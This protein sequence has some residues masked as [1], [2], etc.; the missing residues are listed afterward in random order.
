MIAPIRSTD[1]WTDTFTPLICI[2]SIS[3]FSFG[4]RIISNF[5][6][7]LKDDS[8]TRLRFNVWKHGTGVVI[9]LRRFSQSQAKWEWY[10][11]SYGAAVL[12]PYKELA[13]ECWA[14]DGGYEE[15]VGQYWPSG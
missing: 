4:N 5:L 11:P 9:E 14:D 15:I 13:V 8:T 6:Q 7:I 3:L 12:R 2:T 1:Q 10:L